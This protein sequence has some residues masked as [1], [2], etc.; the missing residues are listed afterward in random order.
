VAPHHIGPAEGLVSTF[1][2]HYRYD[3]SDRRQCR[4]LAVWEDLSE[5]RSQADGC[6]SV[7]VFLFAFA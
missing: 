3:R 7:L 4:L 5:A 6:Y 1:R 2:L